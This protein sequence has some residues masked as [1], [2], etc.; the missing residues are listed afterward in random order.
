MPERYR[1]GRAGQRAVDV[2][3]ELGGLRL[4]GIALDEHTIGRGHGCR[5]RV[6]GSP[7]RGV[8]HPVRAIEV[9]ALERD[10]VAVESLFLLDDVAVLVEGHVLDAVVVLIVP[11]HAG[12][13]LQV[14][15]TM[16]MSPPWTTLGSRHLCSH[17]AA[18]AVG[19][20][21]TTTFPCPP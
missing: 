5:R 16:P 6:A 14:G 11:Q 1:S 12:D 7:L 8:G 4:V 20:E 10:L 2:L 19:M 21:S 13:G 9:V 15:C 18:V 3:A 17:G